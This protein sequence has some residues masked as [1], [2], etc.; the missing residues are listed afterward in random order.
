MVVGD[1]SGGGGYLRFYTVCFFNLLWRMEIVC[2]SAAGVCGTIEEG[3]PEFVR[4]K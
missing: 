4:I 1:R 3:Y 2:C